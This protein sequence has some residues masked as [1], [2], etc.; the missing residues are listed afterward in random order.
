[1]KSDLITSYRDLIV[2]QKAATLVTLIYKLT[3]T[4][5]TR[6]DY[7]LTSQMRRAAISIPSN[8]AEG[9]AR[10]RGKEYRRYLMIAL[11]SAAELE[12][13]MDLAKRLGLIRDSESGAADGLL[14]E[15][16]KILNT[17]VRSLSTR[18]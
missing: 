13:Q 5:P 7:V 14:V 6:E 11:G 18:S 2:W 1:M 8:I 3:S 17:M 16:M 15:V 10:G 9:R 4:F 12:C